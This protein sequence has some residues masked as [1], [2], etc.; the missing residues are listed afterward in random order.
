MSNGTIIVLDDERSIRALVRRVVE[1][2]EGGPLAVLEAATVGEAQ[3][4]Y[5][6]AV[7]EMG[8]VGIITDYNIAPGQTGLDLLRWLGQQRYTGRAVL[9][10]GNPLPAEAANEALALQFMVRFM[11]K[12][13]SGRD[14]TA[15]LPWL[16]DKEGQDE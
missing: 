6:G 15:G 1:M 13:F 9:M 4:L 14:L 3:H 16:F 5:A 10:S 7:A 8:Q 2:Y 12:P 11:F